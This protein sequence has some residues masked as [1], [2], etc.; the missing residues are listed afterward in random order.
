MSI[1]LV[2]ANHRSVDDLV[3]TLVT[4][5]VTLSRTNKR[6]SFGS[7]FLLNNIAYL[8]GKLLV[9]ASPEITTLLSK[10]TQDLLNSAFRTAKAGYFD[11]NFTPLMQTLL[12]D[13]DKS[14][15]ATKEKF[16]R[17]FDVLEEVAERH[18]LA[19]VLQDDWDSRETIKEEAVKLVVPS[20]QRFTQRNAGKDFS[21]SMLVS[22]SGM[23]VTDCISQTRQSISRCQPTKWR[24]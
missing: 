14:K 11:S 8:R 3:N 9:N 4:S 20:L 23:T 21:K 5:L 7:V 6:P 10:P 2:W 15:S 12:E 19:K 17:F 13:K 16:V 1:T 18:K 22:L 24:T